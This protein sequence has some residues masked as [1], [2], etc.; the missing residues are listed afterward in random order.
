MPRNTY[1]D[2]TG[3]A[4]LKIRF[5]EVGSILNFL[6]RSTV[7]QTKKPKKSKKRKSYYKHCI[8]LAKK[9]A[10]IRDGYK[11][12]KSGRKDCQLHGSHILGVGAHPKMAVYPLN[13]KTLTAREHFWWHSAPT[14]SGKWF[15][16]TFPEW[17]E[18]LEE[19]R[20]KVEGDLKKPNYE[21]KYLE[22]KEELN[23]NTKTLR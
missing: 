4:V 19:L 17:A 18:E 8:A 15:T 5:P 20:K 16:T 11:S 21:K 14:E 3:L 2:A 22:L 9:I 6:N 1:S 7:R 12:V 23:E 13:I 10:K